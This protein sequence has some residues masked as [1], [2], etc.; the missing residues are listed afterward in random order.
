MDHELR[1]RTH[2][3]PPGARAWLA[4][5]VLVGLIAGTWS[6][7]LTQPSPATVELERAGAA[8]P[9]PESPAGGPAEA[10]AADEG[11][12]EKPS[13]PRPAGRTVSSRPAEPLPF[14]ARIRPLTGS[15]R[16]VLRAVWRPGCPVHWR[17]LRVVR[18]RYWGF[19]GKPHW[20]AIV[21]HRKWARDVVGVFE[22][23]YEARFKIAS[24]RVGGVGERTRYTDTNNTAAFVCRS[25]RGQSR[26]SAHAYGAAIDIN[27]QHNPY[28]LSRSAI[29]R[30]HPVHSNRAR[31]RPGIIRDND[32]VVRAFRR[33]GWVWGGDWRHSK[34]YM[35][36]SVNGR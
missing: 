34:D 15:Y 4:V 36:F 29:R 8:P 30:R 14:D 22:E 11:A 33:A 1:S 9:D 26:W 12:G 13:K 32:V 10:D 19:D 2:S 25:A 23:L 6:V 17:N 35:H 16:R 18:V 3:R 24:M 31:K 20:G 5:I 7:N 27:P 21:M 28:L